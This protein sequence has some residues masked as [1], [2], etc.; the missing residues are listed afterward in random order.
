[1]LY[2]IY[3]NSDDN[4]ILINCISFHNI[5]LFEEVFTI[6]LSFNC[7]FMW[8]NVSYL[9]FNDIMNKKC[10]NRDILIRRDGFIYMHLYTINCSC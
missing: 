3:I 8:Q 7:F 4:F 10:R 9:T 2:L 6:S 1:M 5:L